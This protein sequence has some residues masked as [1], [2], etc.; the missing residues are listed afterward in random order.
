MKINN[1][2]IISNFIPKIQEED[3]RSN[4]TQEPLQQIRETDWGSIEVNQDR[5][6]QTKNSEKVI[7][8][9]DSNN[10]EKI[11]GL[12]SPQSTQ[13]FVGLTSLTTQ[14]KHA[15]ITALNS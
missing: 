14:E 3:L 11:A 8:S 15:Q 7:P 1:E 9:N 2:N 12:T 4:E 13:S 6:N 10:L 5:N